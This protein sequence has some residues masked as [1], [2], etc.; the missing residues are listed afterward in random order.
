MATTAEFFADAGSSPS[1][2]Q[3]SGPTPRAVAGGT[4]DL[5]ADIEV[6]S[7]ARRDGRNDELGSVTESSESVKR[8]YSDEPPRP[9]EPP[10]RGL[11]AVASDVQSQ[12]YEAEP[13]SELGRGSNEGNRGL[14]RAPESQ[15]YPSQRG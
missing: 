6:I 9:L 4:C 13:L 7:N 11:V 12:W 2:T 15:E 10:R 14:E 3:F 1:K 8:R 5:D